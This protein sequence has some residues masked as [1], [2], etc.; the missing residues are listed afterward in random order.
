MNVGKV[1]RMLA[2]GVALGAAGGCHEDGP[3]A[4]GNFEAESQITVSAEVAGTLESLDVSE[5]MR[6]EE[7]EWVGQVD[8]TALALEHREL[9]LQARSAGTRADEARAQ[10]ASL[11]ARLR[12][13]SEELARTRRLYER[14]AATAQERTRQ[15]G[16]VEALTEQLAAARARTRMATDEVAVV[17]AR[18]ARLADRIRRATIRNP[19]RGTVLVG[20]AEAGEYVQPGRALYTVAPLDTLVLRAYLSGGQLA[21]VRLGDPVTVLYDGPAGG[22][23]RTGGRV[24]WIADEAEFTPTPIQTREERVDQ[25]YAVTVRVPNPDGILKIG[26]PGELVLPG[27]DAGGS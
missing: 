16:E 21:G 14:E 8:T 13:A 11:E 19:V 26:M 3:S 27:G 10:A 6:L 2:I 1:E 22:L 12:S 15:E 5:G 18:I 4:Y 24:S 9:T 25:V 20:L 7:G 17:E 23:D